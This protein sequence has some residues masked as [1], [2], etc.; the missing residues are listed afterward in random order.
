[1]TLLKSL[2]YGCNPQKKDPEQEKKEAEAR[3]A[4]A[5]AEVA[6]SLGKPNRPVMREKAET[7]ITIALSRDGKKVSLDPHDRTAPVSWWAVS[8]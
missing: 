3:I 8:L 6:A 7:S 4:K 2:R 5:R 1:L